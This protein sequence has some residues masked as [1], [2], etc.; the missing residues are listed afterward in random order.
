MLEA[1][2]R[3][4]DAMYEPVLGRP[5]ADP[6]LLLGVTILQ[7]LERLPDRRAATACRFDLR[8]RIALELP[9]NW[10][11]IHP[12]T[13]CL[14]RARLAEHGQGRLALDAALAALRRDGHLACRGPVRIDS[15]HVLGAIAR[16]SRLDC[17]RETL[18]LALLFL[19]GL[20]GPGSW[21]P[22]RSTY[23]RP[24]PDE[25]RNP[26]ATRVEA[27]MEQAGRDAAA[28][29]E[30][31]ARLGAAATDAAPVALL[32][33]VF[34]EQFARG[35]PGDP[36]PRPCTPAGAVHTPHDP[37][38]QWSTKLPLGTSGWVGYKAQ[39]CE[40]AP[41]QPRAKGEPTAA[42]ITAVV[43]QPATTSD[44]GSLVPVLAAQREAGQQ[45]AETVFADAGYVSAPALDTA[46]AA[47]Y[48][49]CGPV[50]APPHG[51]KRFGSDWFAVDLPARAATCPV[52]HASVHCSRI[53]ER[54]SGKKYYYFEWA[55]S[56]CAG[57][58]RRADCLS[59]KRRSPFRTL[60]VGERHMVVQARRA[61]CKTPD[62]RI[63]MR[64]RNAIEGTHS[65]LKR[66]YGLQRCRY[67]G[68]QRT[69]V[70]LQAIAAACN[71]RRWAARLDWTERQKRKTET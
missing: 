36:E 70:Q 23:V 67:R 44:H 28:V 24:H 25:P 9:A 29:L 14:F 33:R 43:V 47:G 30:R 53:A 16:L 13:L 40:T 34:D 64:R 68:L 22:W 69:A 21:E 12:T 52:G 62:Y 11:G 50:G 48:E 45:G 1:R 7:M 51:G 26:S 20:G 15:T 59:T 60:Q 41:E 61:L 10:A 46:A 71:L 54:G 6:V 4:L 57:C 35:A 18:R 39:V 37:Q 2:R 63:R 66:G 42:V 19:D 49:L 31:A 58:T 3:E 65:E 32:Q 27:T 8:W 55:A 17:V 56:D 5:E 38:A